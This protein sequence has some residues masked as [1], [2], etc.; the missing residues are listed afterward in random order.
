MVTGPRGDTKLE[1]STLT[2]LDENVSRTNPDRPVPKLGLLTPAR[3]GGIE[4]RL[5]ALEEK[6]DRLSRQIESLQRKR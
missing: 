2:N 1:V 5:Q 3:S 6:L 4:D